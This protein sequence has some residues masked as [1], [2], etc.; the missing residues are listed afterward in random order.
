MV[1]WQKIEISPKG[2]NGEVVE[3]LLFSYA[4]GLRIICS[5]VVDD[6]D[7]LY[8][9]A[10]GDNSMLKAFMCTDLRSHMTFG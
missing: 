7:N 5:V 10:S 8:V 6:F 4:A 2:V 3:I 1:R 9:V